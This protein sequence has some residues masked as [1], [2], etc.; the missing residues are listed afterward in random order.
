MGEQVDKRAGELVRRDGGC[1]LWCVSVIVAGRAAMP[2]YTRRDGFSPA[3]H[4]REDGGRKEHGAKASAN[5]SFLTLREMDTA[6]EHTVNGIRHI[7]KRLFDTK[8]V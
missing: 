4:S 5:P 3:L 7:E 1:R 2:S 6:K 8:H